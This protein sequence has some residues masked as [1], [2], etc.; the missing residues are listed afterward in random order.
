MLFAIFNTFFNTSSSSTTASSDI[1]I[2][3]SRFSFKNK[4]SFSNTFL[5]TF[6]S[7]FAPCL[8]KLLSIL[9]ISSL[10]NASSKPGVLSSFGL[11]INSQHVL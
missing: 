3:N 1:I 9:P 7:S 5:K 2:A 11:C 6:V 8:K 10:G 4:L